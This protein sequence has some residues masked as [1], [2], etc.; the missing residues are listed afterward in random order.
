MVG[1]PADGVDLLIQ[2]VRETGYQLV[3]EWEEDETAP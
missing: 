3:R 2:G 1:A